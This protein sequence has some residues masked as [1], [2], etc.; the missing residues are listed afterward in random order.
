[1]GVDP[2][3][4]ITGFALLEV[5]K[6]SK[7]LLEC[8]VV[9]THDTEPMPQRLK[10]IAEDLDALISQHKP[11]WIAVEQ[12]FFATNA[13]TAITVGQARGVVLL[14]AAQ[15][16]LSIAEYT[17]LQVKQAVTGYGQATKKQVQAMVKTILGLSEVPKPDDAADAVAIAICHS[18][19]LK[20]TLPQNT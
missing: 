8:G 4:A 19:N 9:I 20:L 6:G 15:H 18:A 1:M 17:P 12:L 2:G 10:V 14:I 7:K 13:K 11:D 5:E 3:T 16:G